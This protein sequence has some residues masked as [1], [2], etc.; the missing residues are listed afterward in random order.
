VA[1][2]AAIASIVGA[3]GSSKT[4]LTRNYP[5]GAARAAAAAA[6]SHPGGQVYA[7]ITYGDWLLWTHPEMAG[8]V[9]FDVRYE[10]LHATEVKRIVLFDS[11]SE[12]NAPLGRPVAYLLDPTTEKDAVKGLPPDVRTVYK[13]DHAVVAVARNGQ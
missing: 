10:L 4:N 7:G 3:L 8:K 5:T 13:T 9:V 1:V 11:G 12:V 2:V 6:R